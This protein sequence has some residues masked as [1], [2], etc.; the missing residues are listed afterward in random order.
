MRIHYSEYM[1]RGFPAL[2]TLLGS[3]GRFD[4]DTGNSKVLGRVITHKDIYLSILLPRTVINLPLVLGWS[5]VG[6]LFSV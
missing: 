4:D 1:L 5:S 3:P 2:I 6:S